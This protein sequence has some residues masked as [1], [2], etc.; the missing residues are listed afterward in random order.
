MNF[1]NTLINILQQRLH[2]KGIAPESIQNL[3]GL[4]T[5]LLAVEDSEILNDKNH[6]SR[7]IDACAD[8]ASLLILV[9]QQAAEL[10][11]VKRITLN[12]TKSL[13]F[14]V[15]LDEV[16]REALRL[17][18]DA[19]AAQI[20]L[21]QGQKLIFGSSLDKL[22]KSE[23]GSLNAYF[24]RVNEVVIRTGEVTMIEDINASPLF[25]QSLQENFGSIISL[26]LKMG[27]Q[28]VGI[29]GVV[30]NAIGKFSNSDIRLLNLLADQAS[31]AI[32]N[33]RLHQAVS[34]QARYDILTGLPNRLA[35]EECLADE[36]RVSSKTN[37]T[38]TIVMLDLDG[39]KQVND[40]YGHDVG[41]D[42]LHKVAHLLRENLRP[43][44]FI[45]RYGGDEFA[46]VLPDTDLELAKLVVGRI[47]S[48]MKELVI[49]IPGGQNITLGISAGIA[50]Y[51]DHAMIS[52]NLLRAADEA[53]Y[54]A[55]RTSLG[56]YK[57]AVKVDA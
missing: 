19:R 35:L 22:G 32:T 33:A 14:Q 31:I 38:F 25:S 1:P 57:V 5:A 49:R 7:L 27:E 41:D 51:P 45:A 4:V 43:S 42:V 37:N 13:K 52:P 6:L 20:F 55:K 36:I 8:N 17:V 50:I 56:G 2:E 39:F 10:D 54:H 44:D 29:M 12:L 15:V 34:Q 16:L 26:P 28:M 30:R 53:L 40:T 47:R 9:Q 18:K 11:A 48:L 23:L 3:V 21:F 46:L 24:D